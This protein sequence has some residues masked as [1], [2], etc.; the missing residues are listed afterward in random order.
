MGPVR[1][2][3]QSGG[4]G[5]MSCGGARQCAEQPP[6]KPVPKAD[7]HSMC[8]MRGTTVS[9]LYFL[10]DSHGELSTAQR[11]VARVFL[12]YNTRNISLPSYFRNL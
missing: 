7:L 1:W 2:R 10:L 8:G 5:R 9:C 4:V 11:L 3:D 6:A 12:Q